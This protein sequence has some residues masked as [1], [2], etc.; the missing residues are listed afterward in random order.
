MSKCCVNDDCNQKSSNVAEEVQKF[1]GC[2]VGENWKYSFDGA[3]LLEFFREVIR[4]H[5]A[6]F[7][8]LGCGEIEVSFW[9]M[10][11]DNLGDALCIQV[12][13]SLYTVVS[14]MGCNSE[15]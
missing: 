11:E 14:D 2:I 4:C 1:D 7:S 12:G 6:E 5:E 13:N 8:E 9:D 10:A 3:M 15:E